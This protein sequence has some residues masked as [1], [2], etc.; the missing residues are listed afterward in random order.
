MTTPL[1]LLRSSH[2]SSDQI[3]SFIIHIDQFVCGAFPVSELLDGFLY[4]GY[5]GLG[6]KRVGS[7]G[8][9]KGDA[10]FA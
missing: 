2:A 5:V 6:E 10:L 8:D 1:F 4:I 9:P 3:F 7:L